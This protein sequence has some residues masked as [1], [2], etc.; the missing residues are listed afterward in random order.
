MGIKRQIKMRIKICGGITV[1]VTEDIFPSST[2]LL[3]LTTNAH[4]EQGVEDPR[5]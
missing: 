3:N 5:S 1:V 4:L 2:G